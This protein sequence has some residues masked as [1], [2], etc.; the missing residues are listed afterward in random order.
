MACFYGYFPSEC[1]LTSGP[2]L[3]LLAAATNYTS[4]N[5]SCWTFTLNHFYL[6]S[7]L[8]W[9]HIQ[10]CPSVKTRW[11]GLILLTIDHLDQVDQQAMLYV[12]LPRQ[13]PTQPGFSLVPELDKI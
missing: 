8:D 1:E 6:Q 3:C 7:L 4:K 13:Q 5:T 2:G 9:E 11:L 10:F 12:H